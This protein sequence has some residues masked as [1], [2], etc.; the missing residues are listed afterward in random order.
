MA[1]RQYP[2]KDYPDAPLRSCRNLVALALEEPIT[3]GEAGHFSYGFLRAKA[4]IRL[5]VDP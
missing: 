2:Q 3:K 5:R 1:E 4:R